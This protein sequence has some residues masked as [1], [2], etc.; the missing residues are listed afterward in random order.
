VGDSGFVGGGQW[1]ESGLEGGEIDQAARQGRIKQ[2]LGFGRTGI[3]HQEIDG[4]SDGISHGGSRFVAHEVA[5]LEISSTHDHPERIR[6][7]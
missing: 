6:V 3:A 4:G 7:S 2:L 5:W 1:G